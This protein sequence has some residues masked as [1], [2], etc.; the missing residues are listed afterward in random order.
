MELQIIIAGIITGNMIMVAGMLIIMLYQVL[1]LV[2]IL[3][4]TAHHIEA[5]MKCARP[6]ILVR[7]ERRALTLVG[8]L[9]IVEILIAQVSLIVPVI[10]QPTPQLPDPPVHPVPILP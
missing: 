5:V 4:C 8:I 1:I 10:P 6:V 2:G 9:D 3:V 7:E